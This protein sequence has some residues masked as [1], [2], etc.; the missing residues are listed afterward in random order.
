MK[1]KIFGITLAVCL[2]VVSLIGTTVAY[3][4]DTDADSKVFTAGNVE[5]DLNGFFDTTINSGDK[6]FPSQVIAQTPATITNTG[7]EDA[8]VGAVITITNDGNVTEGYKDVKDQFPN[9]TKLGEFIGGLANGSNFEVMYK[10]ESK[11]ITVYVLYKEALTTNGTITIFN[12]ITIPEGWDHPEMAIFAGSTGLTI[13]VA[14]YATQ[15]YSFDGDA[16]AALEAAFR[17]VWGNFTADQAVN[18]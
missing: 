8:F 13:D 10:A 4:T 18:S 17:S 9:I 15:T 5:V 12:N 16:E 2:I 1:K 14:A 7:S 6:V 3:F 11:K